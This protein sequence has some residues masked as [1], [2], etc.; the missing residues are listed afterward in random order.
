MLFSWSFGGFVDDYKNIQYYHFTLKRT[1]N[2][3]LTV[4]YQWAG[5]K[6]STSFKICR[7]LLH[8]P[9]RNTDKQKK[10][11]VEMYQVAGKI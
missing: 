2:I 5:Y 1:Y 7:W 4:V 10:Q 8:E 3:D 6:I 9:A 11:T